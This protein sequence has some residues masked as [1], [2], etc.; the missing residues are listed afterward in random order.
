MALRNRVDSLIDLSERK[1]PMF[2]DGEVKL[3]LEL[4]TSSMSRFPTSSEK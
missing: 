2:E 4:V 3:R 1:R